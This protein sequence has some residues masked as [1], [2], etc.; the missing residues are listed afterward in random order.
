MITPDLEESKR[1]FVVGVEPGVTARIGIQFPERVHETAARKKSAPAPNSNKRMN[2]RGRNGNILPS[3]WIDLCSKESIHRRS[4]FMKPLHSRCD[5]VSGDKKSVFREKS[6]ILD[7]EQKQRS[8]Y[9]AQGRLPNVYI[10]VGSVITVES[11]AKRLY[12]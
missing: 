9:W 3:R 10:I 11:E 12:A 4:S 2:S 8:H 1:T 5:L 6:R 7:E